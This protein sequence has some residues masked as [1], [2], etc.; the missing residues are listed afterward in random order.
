MSLNAGG[1]A[2]RTTLGRAAHAAHGAA[3][4]EP[5]VAYLPAPRPLPSR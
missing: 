3:G 5:P 1:G 2:P 4:A